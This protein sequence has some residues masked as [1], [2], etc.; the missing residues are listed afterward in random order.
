MHTV[1]ATRVRTANRSA[2]RQDAA[3]VLY[4][5]VAARRVRSNFAL[6]HAAAH[7]AALGRP[8]VVLEALRCGY[9]WAS[10]RLH[11]FVIEGMADNERALTGRGVT[12]LPYVEPA[13]GEGQGLLEALAAHAC[14]VVTDAY[15]AFFLPRMIESAAARLPV[16]LDVV[17]SNGLLPLAATDVAFP[18]AYAFRR[19]L[20]AR[21]PAHL[22]ETPAPDPLEGVTLPALAGLPAEVLRRWP[23]APLGGGVGETPDLG[24]LPIDHSVAPVEGVSGGSRAGRR[25]LER[26]VAQR[27]PH[28]ASRRNDPDPER[29]VGSG[30]SPYLHFGH[31]GAH[32]VFSAVAAT[33]GWSDERLGRSAAGKRAG[34]WGM[35]EPAEAFLDQLVTWRELGFTF[36]AARDD[37][38]EYDSLPPWARATLERHAGDPRPRSYTPESLDAAETHDPIWNAAQRQLRRRGTIHNYL[39]MLWGKKILEWSP[40]PRAALET[41]IELNNRY[42]LDG[43]D[44]NSSSGILWCLGRF[45]RPWGPERPIFGTVRYMS[46]DNTARKLDLRA[47]LEANRA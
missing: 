17:D 2:I 27:L 26:F 9:R 12:Y 46:S 38:E 3:F 33:E 4:W 44:P 23:A 36:C 40:S 29:E 28:Y 21:L 34:W 10:D 43:R 42:A 22:D 13:H 18:S 32:E 30:L 7:A 11:R 19:V 45:D 37:H 8:L 1:P 20:Q 16:S 5:M 35:S 24:R 47:Y 25:V 6:Q 31:V 14:V 15:P 39:R 41:M